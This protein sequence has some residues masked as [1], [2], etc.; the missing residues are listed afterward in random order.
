LANWANLAAILFTI[1][2][3]SNMQNFAW[4]P[5]LSDSV[6]LIMLKKFGSQLLPKNADRTL[7]NAFFQKWH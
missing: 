5:A 2:K 7:K 6:Y 4:E 3:W 1:V